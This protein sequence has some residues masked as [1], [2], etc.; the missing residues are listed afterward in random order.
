MGVRGLSSYVTGCQRACSEHVDLNESADGGSGATNVSSQH[1]KRPVRLAVDG[2]ALVYHVMQNAGNHDLYLELGCDYQSLHDALLDYLSALT[3]G[4]GIAVLVVVDG[5]Q[6]GDK[7]DTTLERRRSQAADASSAMELLLPSVGGKG[8]GGGGSATAVAAAASLQHSCSSL[9]PLFAVE[10]LGAACRKAGVPIRAADREADPELAAACRR[11]PRVGEQEGEID[12]GRDFD[13]AGVGVRKGGCDA[14]L[15]NDS[16]FLVMDIPGYIPFWSLGLGADGSAGALVFRRSLV[17]A[18]LGIPADHMPELAC[19]VGNDWIRPEG[20]VHRCECSLLHAGGVARARLNCRRRDKG[21]LLTSKPFLTALDRLIME[22]AATGGGNNNE[23]TGRYLT[24]FLRQDGAPRPGGAT[25]AG[26]SGGDGVRLDA[27]VDGGGSGRGDVDDGGSRLAR[28]LCARFY[29]A[30]LGNGIESGGSAERWPGR[31]KRAVSGLPRTGPVPRPLGSVGKGEEGT[32]SDERDAAV[33]A[34]GR[35]GGGEEFLRKFLA[36]RLHYEVTPHRAAHVQEGDEGQR[37][38]LEG[39]KLE[40]TG[41]RSGLFLSTVG[42][43]AGICAP[44]ELVQAVTEG[45][46]WCRMMVED[47][48]VIQEATSTPSTDPPESSDKDTTA[49]DSPTSFSSGFATFSH[50][51]KGLYELCLAQ[52]VDIP[53]GSGAGPSSAQRGDRSRERFASASAGRCPPV[54]APPL[55]GAVAIATVPTA[56]ELPSPT[57]ATGASNHSDDSQRRKGSHDRSAEITD[58]S[59]RVAGVDGRSRRRV[60]AREGDEWVVREFRRVGGGVKVVKVVCQVPS[61]L[62]LSSSSCMLERWGVC[63]SKLGLSRRDNRLLEL[64][65]STESRPWHGGGGRRNPPGEATQGVQEEADRGPTGLTALALVAA[66]LLSSGPSATDAGAQTTWTSSREM[67]AA[68]NASRTLKGSQK[69]TTTAE[70]SAGG[71]GGSN[72]FQHGGKEGVVAA[73][74]AAAAAV[75]GDCRRRASAGSAS[76]ATASGG[77]GG[78]VPGESD[79]AARSGSGAVGRKG[80]GN[81]AGA[82]PA[83]AASR[84]AR[85]GGGDG[86]VPSPSPSPGGQGCALRDALLEAEEGEDDD[87]RGVSGSGGDK[88]DF[89]N[90]WSTVQSAV[91]HVNACLAAARLAPPASAP[92]D[93]STGAVVDDIG[94]SGG[95]SVSGR[96]KRGEYLTPVDPLSLRPALALEFFQRGGLRHRLRATAVRQRAQ[97]EQHQQQHPGPQAARHRQKKT[98]PPR[99]QQLLIDRTTEGGSPGN[100]AM[101]SRSSPSGASLQRSRGGSCLDGRCACLDRFQTVMGAAGLP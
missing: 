98:R 16:D 29:P 53:A 41:A 14:V 72:G 56:G 34:G 59:A 70:A 17:A 27:S 92:K 73:F 24:D 62:R 48:P 61:S 31:Q 9:L 99:Q 101:G 1:R 37:P 94:S 39:T 87:G 25:D 4:A 12:A 93:G 68:G 7:E 100:G 6:D 63:L 74:V 28:R 91:W 22:A 88:R 19:L 36:A 49:S 83:D 13:G 90:Q 64:L 77:E 52:L 67:K 33:F 20:H 3:A 26:S 96:S 85:G 21:R 18:R 76:A 42:L 78:L 38:L 45:V 30:L 75:T 84:R 65:M 8:E 51:R 47:S 80:G 10:T 44:P 40:A 82:H 55:A 54:A 46:F 11:H 32:P 23:A 97:R 5:M 95:D 60:S 57:T 35:V 69:T 50:V 43:R 2:L 58:G 66:L 81:T 79:S 71:R 86:S 15:S 89:V